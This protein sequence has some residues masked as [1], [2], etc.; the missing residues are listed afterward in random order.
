MMS[1]TV[2]NFHLKKRGGLER[3][4]VL[5]RLTDLQNETDLNFLTVKPEFGI[6]F[7]L[8]FV[9]ASGRMGLVF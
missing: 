3:M 4:A 7:A 1:K 2:Q 6:G 8:L 9:K 5:Q